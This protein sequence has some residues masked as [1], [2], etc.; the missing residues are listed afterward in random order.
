MSDANVLNILG[1]KI[2]YTIEEIDIY[3]LKYFPDNPRVYTALRKIDDNDPNQQQIQEVMFEEEN[4]RELF[5]RIKKAGGLVEEIV[6]RRDT[7]EVVEG[8][9][10]LAAHRKLADQTDDIGWKKIR[11]R[12]VETLSDKQ[13]RFLLSEYHIYGK[14]DWTTYEQANMFYVQNVTK[15]VNIEELHA[16]TGLAKKEI[17]K[18]IEII[19]MMEDNNDNQS[20]HYSH[21]EQLLTKRSLKKTFHENDG[22]NS[23]VL[24]DIKNGSIGTAQDVR[25]KLSVVCENA[26]SSA[27]KKYLKDE[28]DLEEAYDLAVDSGAGDRSIKRLTKF[29]NWIAEPYVKKNLIN[30]TDVGKVKFEIGKIQTELKKMQTDIG[31][32]A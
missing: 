20:K 12:V 18:R 15:G 10:R 8:N 28:A 3:E 30:Q 24:R 31:K 5:K 16:D 22:F 17:S 14:T 27:F 9:S 23:R 2:K 1:S 32:K 25:D 4:V 13:I 11:C 29:R 19:K 7:M 21:Y 6:V 26:K